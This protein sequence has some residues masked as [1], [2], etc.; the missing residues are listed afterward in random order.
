MTTKS[1]RE[2][3]RKIMILECGVENI[4]RSSDTTHMRPT[5]ENIKNEILK[6]MDD[7]LGIK[8]LQRVSPY[9][10]N[11]VIRVFFKYYYEY[12]EQYYHVYGAN[13]FTKRSGNK[14]FTSI[15]KCDDFGL[16]Y[17]D[18]VVV[19]NTICQDEYIDMVCDY[20]D[21]YYLV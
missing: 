7:E 19:R 6:K 16:C 1:Q 10:A 18:F 9:R 20:V 11:L 12:E 14:F 13:C 17:P 3:L 8:K 15:T 4:H 2:K 21:Y 5:C